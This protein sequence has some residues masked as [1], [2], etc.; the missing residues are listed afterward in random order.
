MKRLILKNMLY[1]K[2]NL[3]E[4]KGIQFDNRKKEQIKSLFRL[5]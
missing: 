3:N 1:F 5:I 4:H 2:K